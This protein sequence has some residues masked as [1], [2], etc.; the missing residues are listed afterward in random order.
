MARIHYRTVTAP[1]AATI[2][3]RL[4]AQGV[5]FNP[6]EQRK[7][8]KPSGESGYALCALGDLFD[9]HITS[10]SGGTLTANGFQ[11]GSVQRQGQVWMMADGSQAAGTGNLAIGDAVVCGTVVP[12]GTPLP[13]NDLAKVRK[14]TLQPN[15]SVPAALTDVP[16]HLNAASYWWKVASLYAAGTGAP[17][18]MV[19]IE[20]VNY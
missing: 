20:R 7:L 17:G 13:N 16:V 6:S 4:G 8:V 15:V 14:A 12:Q 18:T 5:A 11:T 1:T 19:L 2:T 3:V 10:V 9:G